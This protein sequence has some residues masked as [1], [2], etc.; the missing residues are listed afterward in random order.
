MKPLLPVLK[1]KKR[2]I[3]YELLSEEVLGKDADKEV[4]GH[5]EKTLGLF[6]SAMTGVLSVSYNQ[7]LQEGVIRVSV[8]GLEKAKASLLLLKEINGK[9]VIPHVLGVSGILKKSSRFSKDK[10][11]K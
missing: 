3:V 4:V 7:K 1:E 6:D 9:K 10:Q 2:Y 5:L 11:A 8:A